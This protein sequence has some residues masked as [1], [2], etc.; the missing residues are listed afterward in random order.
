MHN[1]KL[2]NWWKAYHM[3][4]YKE[5]ICL[6]AD[7]IFTHDHSEWWPI[8]ARRFPLQMCNSPVTFRGIVADT[9]YY[10]KQFKAN[11]LYRGYAALTYF[12]Q[13]KEARKFFNMCEDIFKNWDE[14]SW[15]YIRHHK[16][17]WAATDEVYGLY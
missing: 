1:W 17:R 7:M 14:Y 16:V 9:S 5:T 3:T 10:S 2:H 12:R 11:N 8:L 13:S 6:D 15:E 4:P